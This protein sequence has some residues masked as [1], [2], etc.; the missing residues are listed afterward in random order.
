[1]HRRPM[2]VCST[3]P[4]RTSHCS[5]AC[6]VLEEPTPSSRAGCNLFLFRP[7]VPWPLPVLRCAL[8][9]ALRLFVI[10]ERCSRKGRW[11]TAFAFAFAPAAANSAAAALSLRGRG[12]PPGLRGR[13]A[14]VQVRAR[15]RRQNAMHSRGNSLVQGAVDE[16]KNPRPSVVKLPRAPPL[17]GLLVQLPEAPE[18]VLALTVPSP[19]MPLHHE[20]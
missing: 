10:R 11:Y 17:A 15:G 12:R 7:L 8:P 1:M 19:A 18:Q 13:A 14:R 16:L 3:K 6:I 4:R 20:F 5:R 9:H 2:G